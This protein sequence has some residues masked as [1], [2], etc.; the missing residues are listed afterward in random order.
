MNVGE[1]CPV[2]RVVAS[3]SQQAGRSCGRG[4]AWASERGRG[5]GGTR[6]W[7]S[8]GTCS[9]S[10]IELDFRGVFYIGRVF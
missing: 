1:A 4:G 7:G 9:P 10:W 8:A 2:A 5:R 3:S 6:S